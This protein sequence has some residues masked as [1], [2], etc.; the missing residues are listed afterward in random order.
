M[1]HEFRYYNF[2]NEI[3]RRLRTARCSSLSL[4]LSLFSFISTIL[5]LSPSA[6]RFLFCEPSVFLARSLGSGLYQGAVQREREGALV[7]RGEG[8]GTDTAVRGAS[9]SSECRRGRRRQWKRRQPRGWSRG[10]YREWASGHPGQRGV[11]E[12]QEGAYGKLAPSITLPRER[13][14]P[15][16]KALAWECVAT[17]GGPFPSVSLIDRG[18]NYCACSLSK[19]T[20]CRTF[21]PLAR[22]ISELVMAGVK[23]SA[24]TAAPYHVFP[25]LFA[26]SQQNERTAE[27]SGVAATTG[28]GAE[29][30]RDGV[31]R[32]AD[33]A[34]SKS[35]ST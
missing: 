35:P 34:A 3:L 22:P 16:D 15:V 20:K 31:D 30:G 2:R 32:R 10:C 23:S 14:T 8:G 17:F 19:L 12:A 6:V 27:P 21:L 1:P 13:S 7:G 28:P 18:Y 9:G 25:D 4:S 5:L 24:A 29:A 26:V 33:S 11:G